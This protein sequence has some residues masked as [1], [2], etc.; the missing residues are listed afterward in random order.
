MK[1]ERVAAQ[2]INAVASG[3]PA[4][5][6]MT[7]TEVPVFVPN[8]GTEVL[9]RLSGTAL[10]RSP[11]LHDAEASFHAA[12][13]DTENA[14]GDLWP[15][16]DISGNG[17]AKML[18]A[19]N[20]Y[21]TG[22]TESVSVT[23][24]YTLF[25]FG[26]TGKQISAREYQEQSAR[27]KY[28]QIREQTVFDTATAY[29]QILKY[30]RLADLHQKNIERLELLEAKMREIVQTLSGRR[31]EL[32]Q[33]TARLLQ[34]KDTMTVTKDRLREYE[35]QL[36]K[37]VGPENMPKSSDDTVPSIEPIAPEVGIAAAQKSHPILLA[38][39]ADRL[40]LSVSAEAISAG[41]HMPMFELKASKMSGVDILGYSDPGQIFVAFKWNAF[42]GFSGRAQERAL[43]ERTIAAK[44]KYQ[45]SM[46]DIEYKLNSAWADYNNQTGRIVSLKELAVNTEQVRGDYFAQWET[47]GRRSLLE[48]LTAESEHLSATVNLTTCTLDKSLA[49]A[50]LRF[51]SGVLS[52]W[53][54]P[55][56]H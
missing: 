43:L 49:A 54:F 21:A 35:I 22:S 40:A 56:L 28:L 38:A 16:V 36:L 30:R 48:V 3:D 9:R 10:L 7:K 45:Q 53:M 52:S 27:A 42:Q 39:E 2:D 33:V 20:P 25:D 37:L 44:E 17:K 26:K 12:Q 51:E 15:R 46:V 50:K 31:S 34:A 32:T 29:L 13:M 8:S 18:G 14:R 55:E 5:G 1:P 47:A 41:N 11:Q 24:S 19:G 4:S 6:R 23:V